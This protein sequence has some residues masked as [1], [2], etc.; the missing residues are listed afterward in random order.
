MFPVNIVGTRVTL[1][2]LTVDDAGRL[3]AI[4]TDPRV[5]E[6]VYDDRLP[7]LEE[8]RQFRQVRYDAAQQPQRLAYELGVEA[9]GE[10]VGLCGLGDVRA[11]SGTAELAYMLAAGVWG[12]GYAT[13][14]AL[15]LVRF[16][17]TELGLHRIWATT[18][19]D[20]LASQRV[21]QKVGMSLEGRLRG[22]KVVRGQ[23]RDSLVYAVL[24]TDPPT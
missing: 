20:N 8:M 3:L 2:E 21:L 13:E 22:D 10:L 12:K 23:R 17:F 24:A 14:A 4:M 5:F 11:H 7:T 16:G 6:T 18:A 1:R 15:L 19:P 9:D